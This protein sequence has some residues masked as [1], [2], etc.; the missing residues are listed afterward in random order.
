MSVIEKETFQIEATKPRSKFDRRIVHASGNIALEQAKLEAARQNERDMIL[1]KMWDKVDLLDTS[2][3]GNGTK[4]VAAL[5][6]ES[7]K[8]EK[9]PMIFTKA[10]DEPREPNDVAFGNNDMSDRN[11]VAVA[12]GAIIGQE[13]L[14]Q[15]KTAFK[16]GLTVVGRNSNFDIN[17][18]DY[19]D[20]LGPHDAVVVLHEA[21]AQGNEPTQLHDELSV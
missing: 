19:E 8:S 21:E 18:A 9:L 6:L 14:K 15:L 3:E 5:I 12:E 10:S 20:L 1:A 2:K 13:D 4:Q 17:Y 11:I 7:L 16:D